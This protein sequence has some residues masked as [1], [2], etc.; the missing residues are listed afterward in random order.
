MTLNAFIGGEVST[1]DETEPAPA[2]APAHDDTGAGHPAPGVAPAA[3]A[4]AAAPAAPAVPTTPVGAG[5]RL[6]RAF[7][8]FTGSVRPSVLG[9]VEWLGPYLRVVILF[10]LIYSAARA[11]RIGHRAAALGALVAAFLA[12]WIAP[13]VLEGGGSALDAGAGA[14][15]GSMLL[16]V[17]LAAVALCPPELR[18][19][20][21]LAARLLIWGLPPLLAWAVF[22]IIGDTRT[23]SPAW[24]ALLTLAG[25]VVAMGVAGLRTRSALAA[26]A[27]V[28]LLV[29][30]ATLDLRNFDALG[31]RPDGTIN[32]VRAVRDLTP[33]TWLHP[34][35]ARE[36]ADPQLG[37]EV[38]AIASALPPGGKVMT[39]DGR[40]GF[41][42][43]GRVTV[44]QPPQRCADLR[45]T[46]VLALLLNVPQP[47]DASRFRC[48]TPVRV[49]PGSYAVYRV[50]NA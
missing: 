14:V 11:V 17:P 19:S 28:V 18:I 50:G 24:P 8:D 47:F 33:G 39:N 2:A 27:A 36:A 46:D 25:A 16:L 38:A 1:G 30:L 4:P 29:G 26:A 7:S 45:G 20:R 9:R 5:D 15:L 13:A 23:L 12:F 21:L 37:G 44:G 40:L 6:S 35:R 48:L 3:P 31:A 43:L 10:A 34:A 32:S 42:W 49:V 22:G 41:Y